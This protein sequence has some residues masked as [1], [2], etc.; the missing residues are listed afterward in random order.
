MA[1]HPDYVFSFMLPWVNIH[2]HKTRNL[3]IE[4]L[5][6]NIGSPVLSGVIHSLGLHPWQ[7]TELKLEAASKLLDDQ[8]AKKAICAIGEVGIDRAI[9]IPIETQVQVFKAQHQI[10]EKYRLPVIIH[11]VRAWSDLAALHKQLKPQVPWIFHGFNGS[12]QTAQQLVKLGCYLSFGQALLHHTK[13]S[14]V[15]KQVPASH[16][17]LETDD[18]DEKIESIYQKA[19]ELRHICTDE[20]KDIV[21][22]NF[23][24]VFGTRCTK[25]G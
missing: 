23:V 22:T 10:A 8:A 2:T 20:L 6:A 13:V 9:T 5:N 24:K 15:F 4:L 11:C 3:G 1:N 7:I 17:F 14:E 16:L 21:Y 25:T 19:A 12:L 18:S